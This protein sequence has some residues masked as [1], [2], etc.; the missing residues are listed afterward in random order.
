MK[1]IHVK[2]N[3]MIDDKKFDKVCFKTRLGRDVV[4]KDLKQRA[5]VFGRTAVY[6]FVDEFIIQKQGEQ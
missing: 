5:E 1:K 6:N 3:I 4:V 2:Y